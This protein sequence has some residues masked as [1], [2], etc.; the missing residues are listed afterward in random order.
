MARHFFRPVIPDN[1]TSSITYLEALWGG[2][3]V[4]EL[5]S[6]E[7]VSPTHP[8]SVYL[9]TPFPLIPDVVGISSRYSALQQQFNDNGTYLEI[10]GTNFTDFSTTSR[11]DS[12]RHPIFGGSQSPKRRLRSCGAT[13]GSFAGRGGL[14]IY[15]EPGLR[16]RHPEVHCQG[17]QHPCGQSARTRQGIRQG[18]QAAPIHRKC[19]LPI[20]RASIRMSC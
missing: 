9:L 7:G 11:D 15:G 19:V 2:A 17:G 12:A 14:R 3:C 5:Y 1:S 13:C 4:R 6:R 20:L 8:A 16:K 18:R 10:Y